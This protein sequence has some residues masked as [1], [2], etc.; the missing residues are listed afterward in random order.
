MKSKTRRISGL[1]ISLLMVATISLAVPVNAATTFN[2]YDDNQP[3]FNTAISGLLSTELDFDELDDYA[4]VTDRYSDMGVVFSA[5]PTGGSWSG[6]SPDYPTARSGNGSLSES[7][8]V[9]DLIGVGVPW[10]G[11]SYSELYV[12]FYNRVSFVGAYFIDNIAPITAKI[13]DIDNNQIGGDFIISGTAESG[14]SG[15]WWGVV[16][17]E[18]VIARITFTATNLGDFFA[19]DDFVFEK[20]PISVT[21]RLVGAEEVA[22]VPPGETGILD[23]NERW[24]FTL[25]ITV[26]NDSLLDISSVMVK[27]NFGGDLELVSLDGVS[28]PSP[29]T[30]K[31][32]THTWG[33][34]PAGNAG[35][36]LYTGKT[37]KAHLFWTNVG[38]LAPTDSA[39]LTVVV[40]TDINTGTGNGKISG[41]QEYTSE[42]EHCLNS[43]ATATGLFDGW[44]VIARSHEICVEVGEEPPVEPVD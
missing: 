14:D 36:I 1:V 27:D 16:A 6:V 40:A 18:R 31:K 23:L 10:D 15:E 7:N 32:D 12:E 9:S 8:P 37:D 30:A 25:E 17:S 35:T 28:A 20:S 2:D 13:Y 34:T 11:Y 21:K 43:G 39:T 44:E 5:L 29:A 24:E 41:H 3:S 22:N 4:E 26:T 33:I 19:I 42:G 38:T